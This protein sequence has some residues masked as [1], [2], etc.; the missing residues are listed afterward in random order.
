MMGVGYP[1]LHWEIA[2]EFCCLILC[3]FGVCWVPLM[4]V[5]EVMACWKGVF[6]CLVKKKDLRDHSAGEGLQR[7]NSFLLEY[8]LHP[9]IMFLHYLVFQYV[10]YCSN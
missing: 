2:R 1:S 5:L 8:L 3:L 6:A 7:I 10:H 4:T 9:D